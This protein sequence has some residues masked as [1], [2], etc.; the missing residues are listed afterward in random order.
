M[1]SHLAVEGVIYW[2]TKVYSFD[3]KISQLQN[4]YNSLT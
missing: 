1:L 3:C 4:D 2:H